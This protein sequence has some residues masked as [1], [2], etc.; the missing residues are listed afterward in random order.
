MSR[1]VYLANQY[2][3]SN[4]ESKTI[5]PP[6][7][8]AIESLG[9]KVYEPFKETG[10]LIDEPMAY[11]GYKIAQADMKAVKEC[12]AVFAIINGLPPDE[13]VMIEIGM[14][15]AWHTPVFLFRDDF[16]KAYDTHTYPLN[17]M[18]FAGLPKYTWREYYYQHISE[19]TSPYK[20]LAKW[21]NDPYSL[22]SDE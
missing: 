22:N 18:I 1:Y 21:A 13:G 3:F 14:A 8:E 6:I 7:I 17:V 10:K 16:R 9:V 5:L 2:G 19:I 11:A 4:I 20:A 12:D 15:Y